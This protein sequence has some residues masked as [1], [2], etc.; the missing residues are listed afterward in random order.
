MVNPAQLYSLIYA[1]FE[2]K[3]KYKPNTKTREKLH[4]VQEFRADDKVRNCATLHVQQSS[5]KSVVAR[6]I[7]GICSKDLMSSEA[8]YRASCY[9]NFVF[10]IATSIQ[11]CL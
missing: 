2:K 11:Y 7:I 4:S 5:G 6:E 3:S 10:R 9:K 8:R 1:Y